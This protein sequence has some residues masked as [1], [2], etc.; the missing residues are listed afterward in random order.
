MYR[1][2]ATFTIVGLVLQVACAANDEDFVE[3]IGPTINAYCL[4]CHN[5]GTAEA[6]VDLER[7]TTAPSV[8]AK[9]RTW[10]RISDVVLQGVMPPADATQPTQTEREALSQNIRQHLQGVATEFAGDPGEVTLRRLTGAEYAYTIQDLTG[11][12]LPLH[13][14]LT[15]D[16]AGGEGFANVGQVQFLQDSTLERYLEAANLVASHAVVGSGPL[17]FF[18]DPGET[19]LELSAV[20]RIQEIYRGHG[21]RTAAGEGGE[22]YGLDRYPRAFYAAWRYRYRKQ[23]KLQDATLPQ[24]AIDEGLDVRFVRHI[25]AALMDASSTFPL[26]EIKQA[27][28]AIPSPTSQASHSETLARNA[29]EQVAR[30]MRTWQV[31]LA[32]SKGDD[33]EASLLTGEPIELDSRYKLR[34]DARWPETA[35]KSSIRFSVAS[36]THRQ[37]NTAVIT[38]RNPRIRFRK[39]RRWTGYKPLR[40][41]LPEAQQELFGIDAAGAETDENNLVTTGSTELQLDIQIPPGA[42]GAALQIDVELD[43][44]SGKDSVV[45]CTVTDLSLVKE[46]EADTGEVSVLLADRDSET[47][48]Q[49]QRGVIEFAKAMPQISHREPVPS[50]RDPIPAPYDTSYNNPERNDFHYKIKYHRDDGFLVQ[51]IL[52]DATRRDLDQAWHDLLT[53]FDY[54]DVYLRFTRQKLRLNL[55]ETSISELDETVIAKLPPDARDIVGRLFDSYR[56]AYLAR[57]AAEPR[58]VDDLVQFASRAWRR[59][60][61]PEEASGLRRFYDRLRTEADLDH[62][63][64]VRAVLTR[65]LVAPSFLYRVEAQSSDGVVDLSAWELASRLSYFLWSSPPDD[66]LLQRARLGELD[67]EQRL[68]AEVRRMLRDPKATRFAAEFF[69]QWFGFYRF[70]DYSGIDDERFPELTPALKLDMLA[71]AN[72]FLTY[73]VREDRPLDDILFAEYSFLTR[74]LAEHYGLDASRIDTLDATPRRIDGL[75]PVHRGGLLGWGAIHAVTSAPLRTSAVKRGDWILRRILGT[76]VPPP[77]A[78]AGSIPADDVLTDGK[79]VRERLE[80]HRNDAVCANCHIRI[81]PLGFALENFDPIGRWRDTY[82][83]GNPIDASGVAADGTQI[84]GP[85]GLRRYLADRRHQFHRT[86]TRKLI[87]Y[88]LGRTELLTDQGLVGEMMQELGHDGRMSDLVSLIVK[89]KQFRTQRGTGVS[90]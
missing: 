53:S 50:D 58:H 40:A 11:L 1:S 25:W 52:D 75:V 33:E 82:R 34:A 56:N 30:A 26:S 49:W 78:D 20:S 84:V 13:T 90:P 62:D 45:R 7:L 28:E 80:A 70:V 57:S 64:A 5:D 76:P 27:W 19:G 48:R 14:I 61:V 51:N 69:G 17:R 39:A 54:H 66:E 9:F 83:D 87:G 2:I 72:Q 38:W 71:E 36:A 22:P 35:K 86:L 42:T 10:Q 44:K 21:F 31:R 60:L 4:D 79:T 18:A 88:A 59:P 43:L 63:Q 46:T 6:N 8:Q 41:C 74:Q 81:D 68:V 37:V 47:Y 16:S 24:L 65:I 15:E 23:L 55:P 85:T 77:P 73:V 29:C 12:D 3:A 89:S 67:S 32:A